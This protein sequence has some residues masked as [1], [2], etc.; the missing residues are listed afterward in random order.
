MITGDLF[1][2]ELRQQKI[3]KEEYIVLELRDNE[4]SIGCKWHLSAGRYEVAE[5]LRRMADRLDGKI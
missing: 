4:H 5:A 1:T 2:F 3:R